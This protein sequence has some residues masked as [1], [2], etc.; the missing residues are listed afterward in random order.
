MNLFP[1]DKDLTKCAEYTVNKHVPKIF[2]EDIQLLSNCLPIDIA[3]YKRAH[4]N[5]PM[6]KWVRESQANFQ[7]AINYALA[8]HGEYNYRSGKIHKSLVALNKIIENQHLIS[9][10][11]DQSTRMP[12]CFG[13][14]KN[15]IPETNDVVADYRQYYK[16]AKYHLFAW[17]NRD[18]PSWLLK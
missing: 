11:T 16:L 17:K 13:D 18:V 14:F 12:R 8:L 7:W 3:P 5:H 9:F 10:P 4:Y 6:A 1:L 15:I 2:L